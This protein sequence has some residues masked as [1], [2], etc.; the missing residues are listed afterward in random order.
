MWNDLDLQHY[1]EQ[2]LEWEP[3][4]HKRQIGVSVKNGAVH[5]DGHVH[6]YWE[7]CVAELAVWRVAHIRGVVNDIRVE[8][9]FALQREDD[10]LTLSAMGILE[11]HCLV[12]ATIEVRAE[13]GG[14]IL[15]G[16][17]EWHFQRV[18]AEEALRPL[19]GI[20]QILNQVAIQPAVPLGEVKAAIEQAFKRSALIDSSRVKVQVAHDVVSLRGTARTRDEHEAALHAVWST[21]GVAKVEDHLTIG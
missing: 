11:A 6:S 7:K 21:P 13:K 5:L 2:E 4:V 14:L 16:V 18:A 10:D 9:P 8:L 17:V 12:P 1:V 3:S 19:K 20:R 15:S